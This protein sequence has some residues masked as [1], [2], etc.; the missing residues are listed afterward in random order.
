M[1]KTIY[2]GKD[3][4]FTTG[5]LKNTYVR[6][7]TSIGRENEAKEYVEREDF[8]EPKR[9]ECNN[10]IH[11]GAIKC[12]CEEKG[13]QRKKVEK[14]L[15]EKEYVPTLGAINGIHVR[16]YNTIGYNND[17]CEGK[18]HDDDLER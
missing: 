2:N 3:Y 8:A 7:Y 11:V 16:P 9:V 10:G 15:D 4:D 6:P 5:L 1:E 17:A 12:D 18:C 14:L 13:A